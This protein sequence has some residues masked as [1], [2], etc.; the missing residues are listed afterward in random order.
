MVNRCSPSLPVRLV[1]TET[2]IHLLDHLIPMNDG[3]CGQTVGPYLIR[4]ALLGG[5]LNRARDAPPGNMV[6]WRGMT[7]LTDIHLGF[8]LAQDVGN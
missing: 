8:T 3:F 6:L 4:L 5:Y 1:F 2:E 7:R